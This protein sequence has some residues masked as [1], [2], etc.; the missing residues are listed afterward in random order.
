MTGLALQRAH[1]DGTPCLYNVYLCERA[2]CRGHDPHGLH[3]FGAAT[4][5]KKPN[6][7]VRLFV[8]GG[9]ERHKN[10]HRI[11]SDKQNGILLPRRFAGIRLSAIRQTISRKL[12]LMPCRWLAPRKRLSLRLYRSALTAVA[13]VPYLAVV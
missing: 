8:F 1:T 2:A 10:A 9:T 3:P 11:I 13:P 4:N 5:T 6:P 12:G 7:T